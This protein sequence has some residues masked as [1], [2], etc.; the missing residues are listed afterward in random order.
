[1][2]IALSI[3]FYYKRIFILIE[4]VVVIKL[5]IGLDS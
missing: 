2:V 5:I 4:I 1:M 3:Y